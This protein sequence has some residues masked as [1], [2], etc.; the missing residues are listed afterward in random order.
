MITDTYRYSSPKRK[1][2]FA[3]QSEG[4]NG[5]IVKIV[6]FYFLGKFMHSIRIR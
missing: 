5:K 2:R 1:T 4:V 6:E 3:F